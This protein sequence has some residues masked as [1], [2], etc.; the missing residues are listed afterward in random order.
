[1]IGYGPST[2]REKAVRRRTLLAAA[3]AVAVALAGCGRPR[4][5]TDTAA[6]QQ[7]DARAG[8][9]VT[10]LGAERPP[11][12]AVT[13]ELLDGSAFD[14][15]GWNGRVVVLNWW[16]SWCAPCRKEAP[17][18]QAAYE[19][20]RELGVEFMGVDIRDSRDAATAFVSSFGIT[21]PSL[22][23]PAGR[24]ALAFR[25]VPPTVVPSTA[26]L[27]RHHRLAAVF[28]RVVTQL[29]LEAAVRALATEPEA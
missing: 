20:T 8:T 21:Y 11:A 13:G 14:L 15:V 26:L 10:F 2:R 22:F 12:P 4:A 19:A 6:A 24:V 9:V 17:D 29:E 27:D 5:A 23:D 18:L 25:E 16:G 28:R 7:V 3:P 1:M